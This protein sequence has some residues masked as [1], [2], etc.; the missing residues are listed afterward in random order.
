MF[1]DQHGKKHWLNQEK[2]RK[3]SKLSDC[4]PEVIIDIGSMDLCFELKKV[5][6]RVIGKLECWHAA[7]KL[8]EEIKGNRASMPYHLHSDCLKI[9]FYLSTTT[10]LT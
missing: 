8:A 3:K 6:L 7:F 5:I 9:V 1:V 4:S 2:L 10:W